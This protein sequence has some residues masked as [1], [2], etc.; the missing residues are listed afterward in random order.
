MALGNIGISKKNKIEETVAT[1]NTENQNESDKSNEV[2]KN[3]RQLSVEN[4][5]KSEKEVSANMVT[6]D[7]TKAEKFLLVLEESIGDIEEQKALVDK[8]IEGKQ[9]ELQK[10]QTETIEK[11]NTLIQATSELS[12]KIQATE[13]YE[14]Y[15]AEKLENASLSKSVT[16]LE[17][18]LQKEKAEVTQFIYKTESFITL[19]IGEIEETVK[20]LK[21]VDEIIE[22]KLKSF[23]EELKA[24]SYKKLEEAELKIEQASESFVNG[25][26]NQY[27]SLKADCNEM[28]KAYTEKCQQHLETV[29]K[30]S[31]DFLKQCTIQ[32]QKLIEKVPAVADK[33]L[34][35]KDIIIYVLSLF[36]I[37]GTIAQL[38]LFFKTVI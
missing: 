33:K 4:A 24:E 11:F 22:Q 6:I 29:K 13:S 37:A 32:N 19:K 7:R 1:K 2:Q 5:E 36:A 23:T 31:L 3:D 10:F 35:V 28:I 27:K 15:L 30:Q 17:Q 38:I 14:D 20:E 21:N 8:L 18:Q 9:Q 12:E 26:A 34:S 25:S 16:L